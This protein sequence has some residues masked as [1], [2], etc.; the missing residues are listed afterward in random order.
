MSLETNIFP[1]T[2][3]L[4]ETAARLQSL[5]TNIYE[6]AVILHA[7]IYANEADTLLGNNIEDVQA[8]ML[9]DLGINMGVG[10][11]G[12]ILPGVVLAQVWNRLRRPIFTGNMQTERDYRMANGMEITPERAKIEKTNR[13][14]GALFGGLVG[15]A[16]GMLRVVL[17]FN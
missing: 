3:S 12:G 8:Q 16:A 17:G 1:N 2:I 7:A 15:G 10:S 13:L 11:V 5:H 14:K 9:V 4:A 6:R